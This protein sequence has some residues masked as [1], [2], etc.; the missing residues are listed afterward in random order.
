MVKI[1]KNGQNRQ[2]WSKSSKMV[3]NGQKRSKWSKWSKMIPNGPKWSK[4]VKNGQK[5]SKWSK[6]VQ[7]GPKWSKMVQMVKHGR[8]DLKRA[9]RAGLK[10]EV[11]Q[12]KGPPAR[13]RGP[14]GPLNSSYSSSRYSKNILE[15]KPR[16]MLG[17]KNWLIV[18]V[19]DNRVEGGCLV[20]AL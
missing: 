12:P 10:D 15:I 17:G 8:P 6:I 18:V 3:K 13:S 7:N 20:S 2:K 9:Q 4:M 1:A 11:K 16:D 19:D 14:E 5:W